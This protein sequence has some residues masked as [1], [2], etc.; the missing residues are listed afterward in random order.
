MLKTFG[1]N[2]TN[3]GNWNKSEDE[4]GAMEIKTGS[5]HWPNTS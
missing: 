3:F 2:E 5:L 4:T 1:D